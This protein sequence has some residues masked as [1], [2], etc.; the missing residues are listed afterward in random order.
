M[1]PGVRKAWSWVEGWS[2]RGG[3]AL[4]IVRLV[5]NSLLLLWGDSSALSRTTGT[6]P[7]Y[8][9]ISSLSSHIMLPTFSTRNLDIGCVHVQRGERWGFGFFEGG[10]VR[11]RFR[12][13]CFGGVQGYCIGCIGTEGMSRFTMVLRITI[14]AYIPAKFSKGGK[15]GHFWNHEA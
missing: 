3:I 8:F 12:K 14:W 4:G 2:L 15:I 10:D 13:W 11:Q 7:R 9:P 5:Q 6:T 1:A